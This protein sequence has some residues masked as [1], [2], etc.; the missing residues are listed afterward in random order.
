MRYACRRW[1]EC[2]LFMETGRVLLRVCCWR[3]L[4]YIGGRRLGRWWRLLVRVLEP[5]ASV[6]TGEIAA[7]EIVVVVTSYMKGLDV[8]WRSCHGYW[9]H[10]L[11]SKPRVLVLYV[12]CLYNVETAAAELA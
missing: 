7:G 9:R 4:Y 5:F 6:A 1:R 12:A 8:G 3:V 2:V 11:V 10:P